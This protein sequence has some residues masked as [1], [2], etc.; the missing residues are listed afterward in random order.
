MFDGPQVALTHMHMHLLLETLIYHH[1][2]QVHE[3]I[4]TCN[5]IPPEGTSLTPL[6]KKKEYH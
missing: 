4:P 1:A 2:A 6:A 3:R 5:S